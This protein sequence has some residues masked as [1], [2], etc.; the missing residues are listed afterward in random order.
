MSL[1]M[2]LALAPLPLFALGLWLGGAWVWG[3]FLY[4]S[5]LTAVLDR[6]IPNRRNYVTSS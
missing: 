4:M 1:T 6:L 2:K 5:C 3:G